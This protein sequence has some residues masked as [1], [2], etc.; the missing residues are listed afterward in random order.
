MYVIKE[1]EQETENCLGD[2]CFIIYKVSGYK[3]IYM[4]D[5]GL[6]GVYPEMSI[7]DDNVETSVKKCMFILIDKV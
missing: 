3:A 1:I 7:E 2:K 5:M 6:N 4:K